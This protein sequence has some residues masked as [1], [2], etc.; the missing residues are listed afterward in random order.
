MGEAS[1]WSAGGSHGSS[2]E[3]WQLGAVGAGAPERP[4]GAGCRML[5]KEHMGLTKG[6]AHGGEGKGPAGSPKGTAGGHRSS[7]S[8]F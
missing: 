5:L 7:K 3:R 4:G 8:R 2:R 6:T 1:N